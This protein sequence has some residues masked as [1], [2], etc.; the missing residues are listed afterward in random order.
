VDRAVAPYLAKACEGCL[1][2][3]APMLSEGELL[4][5]LVLLRPPGASDFGEADRSNA[6]ILADFASV[7]LR[8]VHL[9]ETE[10]RSR[11]GAERAVRIRDEVLGIVSHDLRN[12]LNTITLGAG[13]LLRQEG[14]NPAGTRSVRRILSASERA[15]RMIRDLLDFTQARLGGGIPMELRAVD[16]GEL[17]GQVV[18]EFEHTHPTRTIELAIAAPTHAEWDPDR[19]TQ[20]LTN[21]IGNAL[22]YSTPDSTIEVRLQTVDALAVLVVHNLGEP[23]PPERMPELFKPLSRHGRVGMQMRSIGLGLF[24]VQNIVTAHQGEVT[25]RS[26]AEEGTTFAMHIPLHPRRSDRDEQ[27]RSG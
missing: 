8:R 6:R 26:S 21:L 1:A 19:I 11:K 17:V 15:L 16:V 10:Q 20:A 3:A 9:L 4:G 5:A 2:L 14:L 13:L 22:T 24:I 25:V 23:I 7:S 27:A 12:P 18:E